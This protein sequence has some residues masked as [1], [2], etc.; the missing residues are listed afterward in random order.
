M[1]LICCFLMG[2]QGNPGIMHIPVL[3]TSEGF[4]AGFAAALMSI[5]GASLTVGK[6]IFGE[7]TYKTGGFRASMAFCLIL[8]AGNGL[9]SL[10]GTGN[11]VI[12]LAATLLLGVGYSVSTVGPSIWAGELSSEFEF[13]RTMRFFQIAYS[14]GALIAASI[15]GI[16]ADHMGGSYVPAYILFTILTVIATVSLFGAY[17]SRN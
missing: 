14:L 15:P 2:D 6:I 5:I 3:Y 11:T 1:A 10:A 17:K 4:S 16:L 8:I 13:P 7:L 9:C 12:S